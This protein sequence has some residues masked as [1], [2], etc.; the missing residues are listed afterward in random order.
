ME[1]CRGEL[2]AQQISKFS[3]LSICEA[4]AVQRRVFAAGPPNRAEADILFDV[5]GSFPKTDCA[6]KC[7]FVQ[8]I[9]DHVL[10]QG[11][12]YGLL[13]F[14]SEDWLMDRVSNDQDSAG[15]VNFE[16]LQSILQNAQNASTRLAIF[17]LRTTVKFR[18]VHNDVDD[19]ISNKSSMI[20]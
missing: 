14:D 9:T 19:S 2:L 3:P 13:E 11:E 7:A 16:L 17:A 4:L 18:A 6:W 20:G 12:H 8:A 1:T 15:K 10:G 5:C